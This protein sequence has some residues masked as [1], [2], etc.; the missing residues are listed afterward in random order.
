MQ[1]KGSIAALS[2]LILASFTAPAIFAAKKKKVPAAVVSVPQISPDEKVLHVLSRLTF[3]PR[4]GDI[5]AVK[6]MGVEK[7]ISQQLHPED[8]AENP[9]L[10]AKMAPLDTLRMS[11]QEMADKYPSNQAIKAIADGRTPYPADA[12][13]QYMV[14]KLVERYKA[15]MSAEAAGKQDQN[16][17]EPVNS[18]EQVAAALSESQR[19]TIMNGTGPEKV[20]LIESLPERQQFELLSAMR[21]PKRQQLLMASSPD[22]R[23]KVQMFNGPQQVVNQD[24]FSGKIY[25]AVY[26]NRQLEEVLTDFWY[27]HFNV[28][29]DKG[30]DRY[31]VTT[32]ERDVI[33]PHVLGNFKDLLLATA[34][35]PAMLF[36]LD[37]NQSVGPDT[38]MGGGPKKSNR[39]L[40][41]NYGR[42]L[43]ELH[44][45][46]VDGGYTQKDVTEVARCFTGW[47][48]RDV[49]GSASFQFNERAH[50]QSEKLVLGHKIAANGGMNDG[51]QVLDILVHHPSTARFI[52]KSLAIRFV[53]DNPS[54]ALVE[55]MAATFTATDG[56]LRATMKTMLDS[57]DFFS[58]ETYRTKVKTPFE[59][60]VSSLRATG[61]DVDITVALTQQL[62]QLGEPLYRKQEPTGYSNKSGEWVNSAALLARMNFALALTNNKVPGVKVD[63]AKFPADDPMLMARTLLMTDLSDISRKVIAQGLADQS[64][65][66]P[67]AALVAG[68]ALGSPDFQKR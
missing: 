59:M 50:D 51:L 7:F 44:T 20:A 66:T 43:M 22:L 60:V 53:S 39:G 36:Y 30:A 12:R 38:R 46:G 56:D 15:R 13:T 68:L 52:S 40:N 14:T 26:S 10:E 18:M 58:R 57:P 17:D 61:G 9:V 16:M 28:Y 35:S 19:N 67:P 41:E 55:R 42:E 65:K 24:L 25:R 8:I 33:R 2:A 21:G 11:T 48:I 31:M 4:P 63:L 34:Q 62:N 3:G 5:E 47:T 32:Y 64:G 49:R 37:N 29:L 45:L 27:N 1:R 54:A 6:K 23:R